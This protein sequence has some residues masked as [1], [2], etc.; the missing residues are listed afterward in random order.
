MVDI[1]DFNMVEAICSTGSL[2][3]AAEALFV[4]QPTLSKRLARLEDELGAKLFH[5]APSGLRPTS[6][7]N[8][9]EYAYAAPPLQGTIASPVPRGLERRRLSSDN[10]TLLKKVVLETDYVC[11]GPME[12]FGAELEAGALRIIPNTPSVEWCSACL[13]RTEALETPLVKL[14][15]EVLLECRDRYLRSREPR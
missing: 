11:G 15:V 1:S 6:I 14:F 8:F 3:K 2:T 5:R 4:S 10:Y 12:V 7:A 13:F 9:L